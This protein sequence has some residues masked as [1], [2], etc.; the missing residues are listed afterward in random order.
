MER[1]YLLKVIEKHFFV[2]N[3]EEIGQQITKT[4]FK[5][6]DFL[7]KALQTQD[8]KLNAISNLSQLTEHFAKAIN[9]VRNRILKQNEKSLHFDP[10]ENEGIFDD[11]LLLIS[12]YYHY[13]AAMGSAVTADF[14]RLVL[15]KKVLL[16]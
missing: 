14:I 16:T 6:P 8:D 1:K 12:I 10:L 9:N 7:V 11:A 3:K 5:L 2:L 13:S 4:D 15:L